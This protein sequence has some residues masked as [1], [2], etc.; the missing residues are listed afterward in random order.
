MARL[1]T[2]LVLV[3]PGIAHA[4]FLGAAASHD[5]R[6]GALVVWSQAALRV[7]RD[8][9]ASFTSIAMPVPNVR[10]VRIEASGAL[11]VLGGTERGDAT[12]LVRV[13][14]DG[15]VEPIE[16]PSWISRIAVGGERLV[17]LLPYEGAVAIAVRGGPFVV[18]ALPGPIPDAHALSS[19]ATL[20]IDHDGTVHVVDVEVST[21]G[22][23]DEI[24]WA[25]SVRFDVHDVGTTARLTLPHVRAQY[26]TRWWAAPHGWLYS[27]ESDG[28]IYA[29]SSRAPR[30]VVGRSSAGTSLLASNGA[31]T[32]A[33]IGARI[34]RID[35]A[36]A[37]ALTQIDG[38]ATLVDVDARGRLLAFS[39]GTLRRWSRRDGWRVLAA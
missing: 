27:L 4:Q 10:D 29:L 38:D 28:R 18:H 11:V 20:A 12:L 9:G 13:H 21:C 16:V 36:V 3:S 2:L 24:E 34:V 23:A 7:S 37:H 35:G 22:S 32:V 17:A 19:D 8:D 26:A 15:Q 6:D 25:R 1:L 30:E 31:L 33:Q 39:E 5:D 14:P